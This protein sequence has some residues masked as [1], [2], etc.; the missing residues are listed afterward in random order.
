[1]RSAWAWVRRRPRRAVAGPELPG[2]LEGAL[3][4]GDVRERGGVQDDLVPG[5]RAQEDVARGRLARSA[6]GKA[7]AWPALGALAR[8]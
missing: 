5:V 8:R 6:S 3:V 1:M 2:A 4:A 7:T